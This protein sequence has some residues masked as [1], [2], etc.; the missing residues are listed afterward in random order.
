MLLLLPLPAQEPLPEERGFVGLSQAL[1]RL[2][3]DISVLHITAHPDDEDAA[4]LTTLARRFGYRTLLLSLTRGEGGANLVSSDFF[5]ALGVL[6]TLE[7]LEANRRYGVEQFYT[8]AVDYGYSKTLD[9]ALKSWGGEDR[10]LED[11][12]RV[13]RRERPDIITARFRG[14]PRD[15]HGHHMFA[16][17][18]AQRAFAAAADP[19]RFPEQLKEGLRPWR[20]YAL[21]V[22]HPF[23]GESPNDDDV[24]TVSTGDYLP[25]LGASP[26]QIGRRGYS[27]HRSQGMAGGE[28]Q[29]GPHAQRYVRMPGSLTGFEA[30]DHPALGLLGGLVF[31]N[32][33]QGNLTTEPGSALRMAYLAI[34]LASEQLDSRQPEASVEPLAN[35]LKATREALDQAR[36]EALAEPTD[37]SISDSQEHLAFLL[38]RKEQELEHAIVLALG[39]E[40]T[41]QTDTTRRPPRAGEEGPAPVPPFA[42]AVPG[43]SFP[44]KVQVL[45]R[46]LRPIAVTGIDLQAPP[47]WEA[48]RGA[49]EPATLGYNEAATVKFQVTV[50]PDAQPTRPHWRRA[51]IAETFYTID[52][53]E[54]LTRP[55]PPPPLQARVRFDVLR[56]PVEIHVPVLNA[57]EDESLGSR[58]LPLG[59]TPALSV[60][61]ATERGVLLRGAKDY[62]VTVRLRS[63]L[64]TRQEGRLRLDLPAGWT[65]SPAETS[66][67]IERSGEES[68]FD[69]VVTPPAGLDR[70]TATLTAVAVVGGREH[71]EGWRTI[72]GRDL[73]RAHFFTPAQHIVRVLDVQ[74]PGVGRLGYVMGSGDEVPQSLR[75]LG[76]EAQ[77]LSAADLAGSDLGAYQAIWIGVRAYAVR[78]EL[79]VHHRRLMDYVERGGTLVVQYQTPEYEGDFAPYPYVLSRNPEEVSE[80][81]SPV[82][83]LAP[84][85]PILTTPNAITERDFEGWVEQ[86]GSKFW[87]SWDAHYTALLET[88][89]TGQPPQEGGFLATR[90]GKGNFVYCAYAWYRQLPQ[91]VPGAYR[92]VANLLSLGPASP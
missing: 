37:T 45:Q 57:V 35:A 65:A 48:T 87:K 32:F 6:R 49:F 56:V 81:D 64:N 52:R 22:P 51:S 5:D 88:H 63:A 71:R 27:F 83:I 72:T 86:R 59:V 7:Q 2:S 38:R 31:S 77:L 66:F 17:V 33:R 47:G 91:G 70:D 67:A 46:S 73:G 43:A 82:R 30:T 60:S 74:A 50:A 21:Y 4:L 79:K 10:V 92:L 90:F 12:V 24:K 68:S 28:P 75:Y 16:G 18:M 78:P 36:A 8:R 13:V 40:V 20:A 19:Q 26:A 3:T 39:L 54:L 76:V 55:F 25:L 62:R 41:A 53:P 84:T 34:F 29:G 44:V 89:D 69:L 85:H 15:G 42:D 58:V 1:L 23:A 61:F 14:D 11:V 80:E 9:E